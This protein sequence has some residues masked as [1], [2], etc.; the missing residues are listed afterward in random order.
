MILG[1]VERDFV[2]HDEDNI[3]GFFGEFRWLSNF[4]VC[5]I[6]FDGILYHSSEAAYQSAKTLDMAER[7][8][9]TSMSPNDARKYGRAIEKTPLFRQEWHNI[10]YDIM[11][12][13][14]FDKFYR[15]LNLRE[16]LIATNN[17]YIE[18]TNYWGDKVWGICEGKGDNNL[19]VI[20][21]GIRRFW[22][23]KTREK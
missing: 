9:F 13:V 16:K 12:S 21:M 15:N 6:M 8:L 5:D 20:L 11:C 4:E 23:L 10:K 18:E 2:I 3:K 22:K 14:V 19:G 1:G 7:N 17:R